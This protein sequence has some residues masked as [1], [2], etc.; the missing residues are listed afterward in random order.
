MEHPEDWRQEELEDKG[1]KMKRTIIWMLSLLLL[2]STQAHGEDAM[3]Y[4]NLGLGSSR[5]NQRIEYF[6]K[7]L[8]LNPGFAAAYQKRGMLYY[9][10][11][12]Y[13]K[14]IQDFKSYTNLVPE[15]A[16]GYR[17]LGMGYL[18]KGLYAEAI[19]NFT[20]AIEVDPNLTSGFTYRAK[21]LRLSGKIEEAISDSTKA[22]QLGGDPRDLASAYATR[23]VAYYEIGRNKLGDADR[24]KSFQLDPTNLFPEACLYKPAVEHT[25]PEDMSKLGLSGI[26]AIAFVLFFG[27]KLRSPQKDD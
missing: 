5:V 22:I 8:E 1:E 21:A 11:E 27:I 6:S 20:R 17:M 24:E 2:A 14:V 7:A 16:E 4:F 25:S 18:Q 12:K 19:D 9:F 26:I 13:D 23:A 3:K 10:Q 15:Q